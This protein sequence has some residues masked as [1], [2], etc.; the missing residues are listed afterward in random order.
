MILIPG[1]THQITWQKQNLQDTATYYVRAVIRDT[2]TNTVLDTIDL[3]DLGSSARF[4]G[5]WNVP[6][7]EK[8]FGRQISIVKTIYENSSYTQ[9]SG[10]YGAWEDRYTI[11]NLASRSPGST[12]GSYGATQQIDYQLIK[13]IVEKVVETKIKELPEPEKPKEFDPTSIIVEVGGIKES[14]KDLVAR[15]FTL[16]E[17]IKTKDYSKEFGRIEESV[18]SIV[19]DIAD[20]QSSLKEHK[21][22]ILEG[23]DDMS[24]TTIGALN[25]AF[26]KLEK[27]Q[28]TF[29]KDFD[30]RVTDGINNLKNEI[31]KDQKFEIVLN[32][33]PEPQP[34]KEETKDRSSIINSLARR[35]A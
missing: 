28:K 16:G 8:G 21:R 33:A 30:S 15:I 20:I 7:D 2:K 10:M 17:K 22:A 35:N 3:T 31:S 9:V 29:E 12:G 13:E 19:G 4:S 34:K 32:R 26:E 6:Q 14:F 23:V 11:F 1:T 27:V 24:E 25:T 5:N 18:E